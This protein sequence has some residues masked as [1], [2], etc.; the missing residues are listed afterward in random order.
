MKNKI[1][2]IFLYSTLFVLFVSQISLAQEENGIYYESEF[3]SFSLYKSAMAGLSLT[4][5]F[6]PLSF[7]SNPSI[8][9]IM[10]SSGSLYALGLSMQ[11][12]DSN[13]EKFYPFYDYDEL[14][15][16]S[17]DND[18]LRTYQGLKSNYGYA[19]PIQFI[20]MTEF[21]SVAILT[22]ISFDM[23]YDDVGVPADLDFRIDKDFM[24]TFALNYPLHIPI[25]SNSLLIS[26]GARI[27]YILRET[28]HKKLDGSEFL[29][30]PNYANSVVN[31]ETFMQITNGYL[32]GNAFGF[33]LGVTL[34]YNFLLFA[35]SFNN[36]SLPY[37][38][39]VLGTR[40]S[41][42]E[43][44]ATNN[45]L[46]PTNITYIIPATL[47]TSLALY[48]EEINFMSFV[49]DFYF[50]MDIV[51]IFSKNFALENLKF[52]IHA[53]FLN[54]IRVMMGT[55]FKTFT[56]GTEIK[57]FFVNIGCSYSIGLRTE[58]NETNYINLSLLFFI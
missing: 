39:G 57:I 41:V 54:I 47:N 8:L 36:A 38:G 3:E 56:M 10:K 14:S 16:M 31:N 12:P 40:F 18:Y 27:K 29:S 48:F 13:R 44:D 6:D 45:E 49:S 28:F 34:K 9:S 25:G 42:K 17:G 43:Y 46:T 1:F 58:D 26:I 50:G 4:H 21:V 55:D 19:G 35:L 33:D 30:L 20:F 53:V 11:I 7:L 22:S 15:N 2:I 52:G 37:G 23:V 24:V 5:I 51:D 32:K